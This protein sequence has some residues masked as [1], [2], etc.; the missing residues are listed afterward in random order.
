MKVE[1]CHEWFF[2]VRSGLLFYSG[3][4]LSFSERCFDVASGCKGV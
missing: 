3:L 1:D 4:F 2:M